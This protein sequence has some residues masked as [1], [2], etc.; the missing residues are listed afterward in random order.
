MPAAAAP[1]RIGPLRD[2]R[3]LDLSRYYPGSFCTLL[4]ADL[5]ADVI[6]VE[7]PGGEPARAR[8]DST[9]FNEGL[10]RGKRAMTLNLKNPGAAEVLRRL[11]ST[12][13]VLIESARPGAMAAM[14]VGYEQ[15]S[16]VNPR[17]VWCS[18]TPFGDGSPYADQAAHE[19]NLLGYSALWH[20]LV[21]ESR[22]GSATFGLSTS[23]GGLM[24]VVGVLSALR[25][26]DLTGVGSRVDSSIID[27]AGWLLSDLVA[28]H[29]EGVT[30]LPQGI[31]SISTYPCAD[32]KMITVSASEAS[33][34]HALTDALDLPQLRDRPP[35]SPDG[36]EA[37]SATLLEVFATKTSAEWLALLGPLRASVGPVN[38]IADL[39]DDPHVR[40]RKTIVE[41]GGR[42]V[43]ANPIRISGRDRALTETAPGGYPPVGQDTAAVL[44]AAGFSEDEVAALRADGVV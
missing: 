22:P 15:L 9:Y 4:L 6:K 11:V 23:V 25:E 21:P 42:Q 29:A 26:R 16:E 35:L 18:L 12:A 31:A 2:V 34:W 40:A 10:H 5:G 32:G 17:L 27:S 7:A 41:R 43:L 30:S 37:V 33:T 8:S 13:D 36:N 1:T 20:T 14:N 28:A 3:V 44:L 38:A 39:F 24:A 19:L